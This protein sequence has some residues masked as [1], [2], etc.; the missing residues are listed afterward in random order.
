MTGPKNDTSVIWTY[1]N[2]PNYSSNVE[3]NGKSAVLENKKTEKISVVIPLESVAAIWMTVM[4]FPQASH[5]TG[6]LADRE[7]ACFGQ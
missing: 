3:K 2:G 7:L 4:Y 1:Q 5:T 6:M